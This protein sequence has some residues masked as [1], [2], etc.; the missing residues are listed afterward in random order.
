VLDRRTET[1]IEQLQVKVQR[2]LLQPTPTTQA[3]SAEA[4]IEAA[5]VRLIRN[6]VQEIEKEE[7]L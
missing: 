2:L 6:I 1:Q 3:S 5:Q 4:E 7:H